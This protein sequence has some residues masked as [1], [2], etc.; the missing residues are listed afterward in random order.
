MVDRFYVLFFR[1]YESVAWTTKA[2]GRQFVCSADV[3]QQRGRGFG[4]Q[5]HR[6]CARQG[7]IYYHLEYKSSVI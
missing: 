1:E 4:F 5:Q 7:Y 2:V 3:V 6:Y